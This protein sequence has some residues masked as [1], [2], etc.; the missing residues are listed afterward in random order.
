MRG[1]AGYVYPDSVQY[2]QYLD[3]A[4]RTSRRFA[5]KCSEWGQPDVIEIG[6]SGGYF[7]WKDPVHL[8]SIGSFGR[9]RVWEN[10]MPHRRMA[11]KLDIKSTDLKKAAKQTVMANTITANHKI[12]HSVKSMNYNPSTRKGMIVVSIGTEGYESARKFAR[13]TIETIVKDKN[14]ALTTG[15]APAQARYFIGAEKVLNGEV[16]EF[17]FETE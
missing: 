11:E 6:H 7:G 16:I 10:S 13:R 2:R 17:E 4:M 3:N 9:M 12:E 14:V 5:E 15:Q 8:V 1:P